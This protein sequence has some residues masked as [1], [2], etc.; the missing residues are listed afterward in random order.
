[1]TT[2]LHGVFLIFLAGFCFTC[3][4]NIAVATAVSREEK[5]LFQQIIPIPAGTAFGKAVHG[6]QR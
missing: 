5:A 4:M 3:F 2:C 6:P 1:M